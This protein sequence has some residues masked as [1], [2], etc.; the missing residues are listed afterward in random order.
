[1]EWSQQ[2]SDALRAI[3]TWLKTPDSPQVFRLFGYAGSGKTTLAKETENMV[4]FGVQYAAF[5]GK[6][7]H[8]L[9]TKGCHNARTI[10]SLIYKPVVDPQ[11][12]KVDF[13]L[14]PLGEALEGVNL[15]VI[16]EV[17]MVDARLGADLESFGI[18]ILVLGDPAQL[19]PIKGAGYFTDVRPDFMLTEVHR[20]ALDSPIIRLATQARQK[21]RIAVGDY[22]DARVIRAGTVAKDDIMTAD[23]VICGRN[24]TRHAL[25]RQ[26]RRARGI[27]AI[28]PQIGEKLICLR[29]DRDKGFL[30]GTTWYV[31]SGEVSNP[32]KL[33]ANEF[34][35]ITPDPREMDSWF[36]GSVRNVEVVPEGEDAFYIATNV[37]IPMPFFLGTEDRLDWQDLR[38]MDQFTFGY[39][40]T[41]HKSQGSQWDKLILY[42]ESDVFREDAWRHLY[43]GITRAAKE[44][45]LVQT[46]R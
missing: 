6:A 32:A 10:H 33:Y 31:H 25:N 46:G 40:I 5:T 1:M 12:G 27:D 14:D 39:A 4:P 28:V 7:S 37:R 29:N 38:G 34:D 15:L 43:T 45:V 8:V 16:D 41:V 18:K 26:I 19:P 22:G 23:Q 42:D 36:A 20:Q 9:R 3:E 30:N 11:N 24:K 2:Q 21:Q 44:L 17:S 35:E 13:V